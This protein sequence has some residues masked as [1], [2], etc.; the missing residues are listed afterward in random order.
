MQVAIVGFES[1]ARPDWKSFVSEPKAPF[2]YKDLVKIEAYKEE[3][4]AKQ[5]AKAAI[6]PMTGKLTKVLI[7]I[8]G[9]SYKLDEKDDP[10][11]ILSNDAVEAVVG[12]DI[13]NFLELAVVKSMDLN[14]SLNWKHRWAKTRFRDGAYLPI[15][16]GEVRTKCVFDPLNALGGDYEGDEIPLICQRFGL[17]FPSVG[18]AEGALV[19]GL[20]ACKKLGF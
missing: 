20:S 3:A 15:S 19:L 14:G 7:H 8:S 10:M 6:K 17:V 16:T 12:L 18:G 13:F 2:N 9:K 1:T 11:S 5:Q 4:K